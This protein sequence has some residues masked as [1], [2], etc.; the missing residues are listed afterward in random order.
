MSTRRAFVIACL[1]VAP[2]VMLR[3]VP[4]LDRV[5]GNRIERR[6]DVTAPAPASIGA[7][8]SSLSQRSAAALALGLLLEAAIQVG[9]VCMFLRSPAFPGVWDALPWRLRAA[10]GVLFA[11][12]MSGFVAGTSA[13]FPFVAWRMYP[14]DRDIAR[15]SQLVAE[16]SDG[17]ARVI[18]ADDLLPVI[19]RHRLLQLLALQAH[20]ADA[21]NDEAERS[22][23]QAVLRRT[24]A[25]LSPLYKAGGNTSVRRISFY[26][27]HIPLDGARPPWIRDRRAVCSVE[28]G[29]ES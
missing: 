15:V 12:L 23:R 25:G 19:G 9:L 21:S 28:M 20:W 7:T 11:L 24:L 6:A 8:A 18:D 10:A 16:D 14:G 2:G 4:H 13:T 1:I 29:A 3:I 22:K 26:V 5:I 17:V 27:A